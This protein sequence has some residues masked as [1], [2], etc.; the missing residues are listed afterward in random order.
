MSTCLIVARKELRDHARDIRSLASTALFA[1]M[2]P[3]VVLLVSFSRVQDAGGRPKVLLSMASVFA[4][5]TA[6]AGGMNLAMDATAGERERRSL[7]PLLL[8]PV[9]RLDLVIGKWMAAAALGVAALTLTLAAFLGVLAAS[10]P[11]SIRGLAPQLSA[12]MVCGL[13]PLAL[14][15]SALHLV[16]AANSRSTKEAHGWLSMMAFVPM[17]VG[18]FLVFFPSWIGRWWFAVPIVGQ[19]S[20][21]ARSLEGQ[22]VRLLE[23]LVLAAITLA[24]SIPALLAARG[25]LDREDA[26][27]G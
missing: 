6:F 2:G 16:V 25:V 11:A 22:P 21:V 26:L 5:V 19:Q 9:S 14:L 17:L 20:L 7:V 13:V 8:S 24:A 1:L 4:L 23:G 15:G 27:A 12:W 3:G 10:A 18:M